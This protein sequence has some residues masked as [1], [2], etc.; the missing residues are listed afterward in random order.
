MEISL[1]ASPS[2]CHFYRSNLS[3]SLSTFS[4]FTMGR[5]TMEDQAES[6]RRMRC[7][8]QCLEEGYHQ[9]NFYHWDET[10]HTCT[11]GKVNQ[12]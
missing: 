8:G 7:E 12:V 2:K 11:W 1:D 10:N 6:L 3:L 9:C 5:L 4:Y